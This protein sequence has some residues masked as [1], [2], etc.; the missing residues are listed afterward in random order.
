M[1]EFYAKALFFKEGGTREPEYIAVCLREIRVTGDFV[2]HS[3][4]SDS[5]SPVVVTLASLGDATLFEKEG[6]H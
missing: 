2:V 4:T 5:K 1:P 6:F 3:T